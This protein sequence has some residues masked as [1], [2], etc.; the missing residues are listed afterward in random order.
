ML[1]QTALLTSF[2]LVLGTLYSAF[3]NVRANSSLN[4]LQFCNLFQ[5]LVNG[6]A[7]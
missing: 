7:T 6:A 2:S 5:R 4:Q 1:Q 3:G